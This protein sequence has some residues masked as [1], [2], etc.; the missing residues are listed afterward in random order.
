MKKLVFLIS[1]ILFISLF[2]GIVFAADSLAQ[3]IKDVLTAFLAVPEEWLEPPDLIYKFLL[4]FI[5][6]L[7][8]ALGFMRTIRIFERATGIQLVI[9]FVFALATLP[10]HVFYTV[11][12]GVNAAMGIYSYFMFIGLFVIGIALYFARRTMGWWMRGK[13]ETAAARTHITAVEQIERRLKDIT[14]QQADLDL[15]FSGGQMSSTDY[16]KTMNNLDKEK[17]NL[18]ARLRTLRRRY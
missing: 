3:N 4:P 1:L 11:V 14:E 7:A 17:T 13:G 16:N 5:G 6:I 2:S 18:I 12:S 15:K 9:A 8:I 10:T